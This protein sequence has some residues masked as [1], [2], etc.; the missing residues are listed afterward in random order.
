MGTDKDGTPKHPVRLRQDTPLRP[1]GTESTDTHVA[2]ATPDPGHR[3][4]PVPQGG[5]ATTGAPRPQPRGTG[6]PSRE[7][8]RLRHPKPAA[9][10]MRD[11]PLHSAMRALLLYISPPTVWLSGGEWRSC[12]RIS[13]DQ[14]AR[15]AGNLPCRPLR[16]RSQPLK[17]PLAGAKWPLGTHAN[18]R[19]LPDAYSSVAV[20]PSRSQHV[21]NLS[22]AVTW[23]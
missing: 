10:E 8:R 9:R 7:K 11:N 5:V 6:Q 21:S 23:A 1:M 3:P 18:F 20:F 14:G 17:P 2:P 13:A 15:K 4:P 12:T 19:G 22:P 16:T